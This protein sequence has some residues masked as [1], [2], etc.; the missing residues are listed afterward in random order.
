MTSNIVWTPNLDFR[1]SGVAMAK[2]SWGSVTV[3]TISRRSVLGGLALVGASRS[4]CAEI[5][6]KLNVAASEGD[7]A[8]TRYAAEREG[9]RPGVVVLHGARGVEVRP[10]AYE[11]YAN[12]LSAQ[13]IDAYLIRYYSPADNLALEKITTSERRQAYQSGRF[14][15]WAGRVSSA[16]TAILARPDSSG[17]LGLLGF[18][19]GG[20]IAAATAAR[21]DR[22]AALAVLYGGMPDKIV[23][24]VKHLPPLLELH[25]D[26]DRNVAFA[27]GEAL[28]RLAKTVGADAEL[29]PYPGKAHGFDFSDSDPMAADAVDRVVRFFQARLKTG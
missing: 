8:L 26:A 7:V 12:A 10:R 13:G 25:G 1:R 21:D 15:V 20:Y 16:M 29:V 18:S 5:P 22:V 4:V 23:P 19:L 11:R 14:E 2:F 24:E 9:K 27:Q 17:R 28:V 6:E 3:Q